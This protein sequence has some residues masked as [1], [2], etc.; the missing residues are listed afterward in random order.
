MKSKYHKILIVDDDP[1]QIKLL[2]IYLKNFDLDISTAKNGRHALHMLQRKEFDLILTDYQMP[3][4]DG[5]TMISKIR[6][7]LKSNLPIVVISAND[8]ELNITKHKNVKILRKPFTQDQIKSI[9]K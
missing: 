5:G 1:N 7:E 6:E 2:K 8:R 3:E 9:F 4:M